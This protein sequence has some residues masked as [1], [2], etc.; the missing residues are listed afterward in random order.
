MK[1]RS[2]HSFSFAA[3]AFIK[4]QREAFR[5][6]AKKKKKYIRNLYLFFNIIKNERKSTESDFTQCTAWRIHFY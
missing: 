5:F 1:I 6:R 3:T 2:V 4:I